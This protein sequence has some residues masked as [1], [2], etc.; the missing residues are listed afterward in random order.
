MS[1]APHLH[2]PP[3]DRL[4]SSRT[5]WTRAHWEATADRMLD[6]LVPYATPGFAQYR[7]PGRG[8]WSGVVSDGLEGFARSFLLAACRI[9][10]AGGAADPALIERYTAGLA[11]GTDPGSG[12]AWP[13]LTD[14]SQQMVEAASVAV[15]LH[16]TRPWIW[17]RLDARVQERVVDWFSGFVGGR[18]WDNNWRL[19]QV[20]SE[21]FL[22]SVGAPYSRSDIESNLDRI[23]DWYVGD[24][25]YT[26]GDGRN[27]DYYIGWA[28]HLYPLLWS[29]MA[30]ADDG[31]RT[32]VYRKRLR[33]FLEDYPHFFGSDGA[34]VHQ[35]RSLTYR[36]AALAPVWMGALADCTPLAPGLTRRLASGT[37]R[38]FAERGVPDERGLLTLGWYDTFLPSTQP[39]SGPAS[40]YWASKGF[41]GLL[42]PADHEVWTARELPLPIEESDQ[43]TA[44]P[45]TGWLLHGTRDDG[46]VR[47]VNHGSDHNPPFDEAADPAEGTHD[48]H[49]ARFGYSTATAPEAAPHAVARSIDGHLALLAPDGTPSPRSRIHPLRC[50][51]RVAASWYAARLPG[52][53]RPYRI[54]TTSVLH[55]PWEIRVHRVEAPEG[56]VVREGGHPVAHARSP[57]ALSGPDWALARTADGL[58]SALIALHGWDGGTEGA[59]VARDVQSNAYGPHSAIPYL[60]SGP[61]P[62]GRSI[63]VSLVALS[64]DAVHPEAL[65]DAV[66]VGAGADSV[67]LTFLD[68]TTV[69]V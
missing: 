47:L 27:F 26:D 10:G 46:I 15:A 34:P 14:C 16:E 49:Y 7:L 9:A 19:F 61:H 50:E 63:H 31:G 65:R 68:G 44:L 55:G 28:M 57:F 58:S 54:E 37:M 30:G 36:F 33:R 1:V 5:G 62:G 45:A 69:E 4:L 2:L 40:P 42:L 43:Y 17:D 21:Q 20:V 23:E 60:R 8:S 29:R 67:V 39:Y 59:A 24:G 25:W 51:G 6:A 35:G 53:D 3:P 41:L 64:R 22:A 38:H 66:R 32:E 52:D 56:A 13:R 11:A 48:P 12:E 18:T